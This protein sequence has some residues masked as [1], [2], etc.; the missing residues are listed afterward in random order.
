[1]MTKDPRYQATYDYVKNSI[2][3]SLDKREFTW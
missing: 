2:R 1:M 3:E